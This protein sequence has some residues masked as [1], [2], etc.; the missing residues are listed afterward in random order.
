M[1]NVREVLMRAEP[2]LRGLASSL[3]YWRAALTRN[4]IF[5]RKTMNVS[6]GWWANSVNSA[7]AWSRY[8][9]TCMQRR[10]R[11]RIRY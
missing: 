2:E 4:L 5:S 1:T 3:I 7:N 9:K 8:A 6:V 10:G 11:L